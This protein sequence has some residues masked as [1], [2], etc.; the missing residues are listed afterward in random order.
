ME[1][2]MNPKIMLDFAYNFGDVVKKE[3][4][5]S[6]YDLETDEFSFT[7]PK[8]SASARIKYFNDELA[9]YVTPEDKI[10][11]VFIEY[12]RNNFIQHH[13]DLEGILSGIDPAKLSDNIVD[14]KAVI[15]IKKEN[16]EKS[17]PELEEIIKTSITDKI[18]I[19]PLQ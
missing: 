7:T 14:E 18:Q 13:Q 12:F 15:D 8:L 10:E 4:W 9:F 5:I 2:T 16:L 1:T 3:G 11:G 19:S 17:V 6:R